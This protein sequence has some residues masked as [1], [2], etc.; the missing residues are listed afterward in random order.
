[1]LFA[2]ITLGFFCV[3]LFKDKWPEDL[4]YALIKFLDNGDG[5]AATSGSGI[6]SG[7]A[8][9]NGNKG[10]GVDTFMDEHSTKKTTSSTGT[11][12]TALTQYSRDDPA[13]GTTGEPYKPPP[14]AT[15]S[16]TATAETQ[17]S[18][19][20]DKPRP[21]PTVVVPQPTAEQK[22]INKE[23]A[24]MEEL[25]Q[26][27]DNLS[28][29][30]KWNLPFKSDRDVAVHWSIPL[31]GTSLVDQI[32]GKCYALVQAGDQP[33][34]ITGHEEELILNVLTEDDGN[35]YVNVDMG[36]L[37]G[38]KRAKDL[39][40]ATS[41]VADVIRSPYLYETALLFQGTS[42]YAKCFTMV[43]HPIDRAV[44]VFRQLKV[45]STNPVFRSMTL[46]EY[47]RSSFSENNWMVRFLANELDGEIDQHH[48]ELA[49]HVLGRK[50]LIGLTEMFEESMRRF[51]K[52]FDWSSKAS[53]EALAECEKGLE[54]AKHVSEDN[55]ST[56]MLADEKISKDLYKEGTEIYTLLAEK[57]SF[58]LELYKYARGLF[59]RQSL[60][61]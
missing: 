37:N 41:N 12:K 4:R 14:S 59:Q 23:A 2:C 20:Q 61:S 55:F 44:D 11:K 7:D 33:S 56:S 57:N 8:Y 54:I 9:S 53:A 43:R 52:Y 30:L 38:I 28:K 10:A 51:V 49:Q 3:A 17:Q 32:L 26:H 21:P 1:M 15:K 60:Y 40:L 5:S 6:G 46:E 34:H 25:E 35:K 24:I 22:L 19:D 18:A 58:D 36:S 50:C 16:N 42:R 29:Y 45:S 13:A 31:S 39:H 47:A 27:L 48:L